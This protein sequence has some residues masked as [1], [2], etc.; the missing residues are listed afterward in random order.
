MA[1]Y[2]VSYDIN[3]KDAFEYDGLWAKLKELGAVRILY[4]EW[5]IKADAGKAGAIYGEVAPKTQQKDRL[6][7]QEL[8]SDAVWD[9]LS[10]PT[11]HSKNCL[12][13]REVRLI[14]P[15]FA[16]LQGVALSR[17]FILGTRLLVCQL[18]YCWSM[19]LGIK[20]IDSSLAP[21][22]QNDTLISY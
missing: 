21:L 15:P 11:K 20:Y 14:V 3:E 9:Q 8:T 17:R 6:L 16:D 22:A 18:Y 4:S 10:L 2:L 5:A 19:H 12:R 1:L 7:V 13:A